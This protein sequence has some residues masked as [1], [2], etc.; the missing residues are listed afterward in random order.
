MG[1][2]DGKVG[3]VIGASSGIGWRIVEKY[4]EEGAQ[5]IAAARRESN[6]VRCRVRFRTKLVFS[7]RAPVR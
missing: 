1:I 5:V 7:P 2:L 6:P 4:I 3:V